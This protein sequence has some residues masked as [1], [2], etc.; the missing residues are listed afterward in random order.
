MVLKKFAQWTKNKVKSAD[1][2]ATTVQMT[3]N[4]KRKFST[5]YGGIIS[6]I[7]KTIIIMYA[8]LL[9]IRIFRKSDSEKLTSTMIKDLSKDTEQH[10]IGKG[11]FAFAVRLIW[12]NPELLLDTSYFSFMVNNAQY[13]RNS[14][15]QNQKKTTTIEME[16]WGDKFPNVNSDIYDKVGLATFLCPKNTDYYLQANYHSDNYSGIEIFVRK[17]ASGSCQSDA[18]IQGVLDTHQVELALLNS[19]YD[20]EDYEEPIKTYL[21]DTNIFSLNSFITNSGLIE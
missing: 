13:S 20:F 21:E 15:F 19:Y 2:Y 16:T 18:T 1:S 3:F 5:F 7:I 4:G 6:L 10:F 12:P 9:T 17:C 8:I 14:T 11:T